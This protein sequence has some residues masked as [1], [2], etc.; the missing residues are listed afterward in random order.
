MICQLCKRKNIRKLKTVEGIDIFECKNCQLGFIDPKETA[1]LNPHKEYS[2]KGYK[3]N[4][5]KLRLRFEKLAEKK[6]KFQ[7]L[8]LKTTNFV[9]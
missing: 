8:C 6:F 5:S 3:E 1:N 4:E 2:L 7:F 9:F